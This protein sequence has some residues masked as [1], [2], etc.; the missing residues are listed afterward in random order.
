[1]KPRYLAFDIE[2]AKDI[3]GEDFIWRPY[4]P[5]GISCAA[6]LTSD[7]DQPVLWHGKMQDGLPAVR[8]SRDDAQELVQYLAQM[9]TE[10]YRILTW[11]GLAARGASS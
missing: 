11:N 9:A 10:G 6:T 7:I 8:M 5:L 4:R 3:P 1:M 2:T